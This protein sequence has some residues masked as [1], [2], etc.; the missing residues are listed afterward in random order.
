MAEAL[1]ASLPTTLSE[2][3]AS[4]GPGALIRRAA[5]RAAKEA[6]TREGLFW[7]AVLEEIAAK[8]TVGDDPG[9]QAYVTGTI[10]ALRRRFGLKRPLE[11]VRAQTRERVRRHRERRKALAKAKVGQDHSRGGN[12]Q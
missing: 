12:R 4:G 1:P 7:L 8:S 5:A 3:I 11:E 10:R 9:D 6:A 2:R